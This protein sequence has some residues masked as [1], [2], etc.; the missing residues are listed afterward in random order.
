MRIHDGAYGTLLARHLHGD[1]TV[2]DLCVRAPRL[3]I[4]AHRAYL[5]S[6]ATA[7]QTNS[8]LVHLRG[9][10]RRRSV[11]R[12]AALECAREAAAVAQ[13]PAEVFVTIGPADDRPRSYWEPVEQ[14][15]DAGVRSIVCETVTS[16][17]I[18]DAFLDAWRE[19]ASGVV[20]STVLLGCSVDPTDAARAGW[21][22]DLAGDAPDDVQLGLNCCSGP[23]GIGGL[24]AQ[25]VEQRGTSWAMP[26]AG[27]PARTDAPHDL[28]YPFADP[29]RWSSTLLDE[30]TGLDLVG[31]GGCCG[32]TPAS[33]LALQRD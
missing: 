28:D 23:S 18:A 2:D 19:V 15:L 4:D 14:A 33:I 20:D 9:S 17:P 13:T 6:G 3:V 26:S 1:E 31:I 21:V 5:E 8:F 7:I 32:T 10:D 24:L 27:I 11:L 29:T 12:A 25:I 22:V 30:I 16:R